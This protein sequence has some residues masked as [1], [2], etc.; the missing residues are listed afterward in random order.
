M[1]VSKSDKTDQEEM[2][3]IRNRLASYS[4]QQLHTNIN[5]NK[6]FNRDLAELCQVQ[7]SFTYLESAVD[8]LS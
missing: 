3:R 6:S 2:I 5:R 4:S 8:L 1:G 7:L